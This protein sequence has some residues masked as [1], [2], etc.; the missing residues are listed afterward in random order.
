MPLKRA[1]IR[2]VEFH[3]KRIHKKNEIHLD[4]TT[5]QNI[6]TIKIGLFYYTRV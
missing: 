3:A 4:K 5:Y 1:F 2:T 6:K